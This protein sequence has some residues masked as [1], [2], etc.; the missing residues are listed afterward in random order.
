MSEL[1]LD[2]E[3]LGDEETNKENVKVSGSGG[4]RSG[5]KSMK[6]RRRS[7]FGARRLSGFGGGGGGGESA[8]DQTKLAEMYSAIIKLSSENK[9]NAKNSW[10]LNLIEH[11]DHMLYGEGKVNFQKAS[12]TLDASIK[13]Y[14]YR[15]DE[16][17]ASTYRVLENLSR[18]DAGDGHPD[19]EKHAKLGS[20][21]VSAKIGCGDTLEK[22]LK[23]INMGNLDKEFDVD[24]LFHKMSKTFDEAGSKG[25]LLNNLNVSSG[26]RVVFDSG[27]LTPEA[28]AEA[29]IET[30]TEAQ[31][32]NNDTDESDEQAATSAA[33]ELED[34]QQHVDAEEPPPAIMIDVSSLKAKLE[35]LGSM[36]ALPLCP[37]FEDFRKELARLGEEEGVAALAEEGA[38]GP[39]DADGE[40]DDEDY[41]DDSEPAEYMADDTGGEGFDVGDFGD[42]D[43]P[44]ENAYEDEHQPLDAA[45]VWGDVSMAS[46][47]HQRMSLGV[48]GGSG[49]GGLLD[50]LCA[51]MKMV[52]DEYTFFDSKAMAAKNQW[53]GAI[54]WK[55]AGSSL[56]KAVP[57]TPKAPAAGEDDEDDNATGTKATR[58]R[59]SAFF[60]D[61]DSEPVSE[62]AFAPPR[63]AGK[64]SKSSASNGAKHDSTML[65]A[66]YLERAAANVEAY[67]LPRDLKFQAKDL[68]R[69]FLRPAAVIRRDALAGGGGGGMHLMSIDKS[70]GG[71][72]F[73]F[74]QGG[75]GAG[76]GLGDD[77]QGPIMFDEGLGGYDDD[78]VDDDGM[79][80]NFAA[81]QGG[82]HGLTTGL[83]SDG[84]VVDDWQGAGLLKPV[85]HV[86]KIQVNYATKA[87]KV[88]VRRLKKD[89]WKKIDY[90]QAT[91]G[92][93]NEEGPKQTKGCGGEEAMTFQ[94]MVTDVNRTQGQEQDAVTLPFYFICV[95]HLAN[96]KG[97][98]L[99][100]RE[101]LGMLILHVLNA[102]LPL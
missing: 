44:G 64:S 71:I 8:A 74:G 96:E 91:G 60:I 85:R 72:S 89:M 32:P 87:K 102:A 49:K 98:K 19:E 93:V 51:D 14:S 65:T 61:M 70:R 9:I 31:Q 58:S 73:G 6:P 52:D 26:C 42:G 40:D 20:K 36:S 56:N 90:T 99:E 84:A 68:A 33:E 34:A 97:L 45:V 48:G 39:R 92:E 94:E 2:E 55:F 27:D 54:H 23:S 69:L 59:K 29:S 50:K 83:A 77:D 78:D 101:D 17:V 15:V 35:S 10:S 24:P 38:F 4:S 13:I 47:A 3:L 63:S 37:Q 46:L 28:E 82:D 7:S 80:F 43:G 86:E 21:D 66:R 100:G 88:D 79:G 22:N 11:M 16:T 57:R 62:D 53:A 81:A 18:S 75:A 1:V 76:A 12:C 30:E 67:S 95:L 5:R 41:E 25:M